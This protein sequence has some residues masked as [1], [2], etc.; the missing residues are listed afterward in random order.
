M[1]HSVKFFFI[2]VGRGSGMD[3]TAKPYI[4]IFYLNV[5]SSTS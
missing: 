3:F 5:S 2:A 1:C 4:I